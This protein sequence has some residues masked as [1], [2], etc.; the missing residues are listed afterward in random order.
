MDFMSLSICLVLSF[1]IERLK[2]STL[3]VLFISRDFESCCYLF[4]QE[5]PTEIGDGLM[6]VCCVLDVLI[7]I[8]VIF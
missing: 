8:F 7:D 4:F 5:V 2:T 1:V 3:A 6:N